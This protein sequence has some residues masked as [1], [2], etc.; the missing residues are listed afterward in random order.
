MLSQ[1]YTAHP[2]LFPLVWDTGDSWGN[3]RYWWYPGNGYVPW[4]T[5]GGT[6]EPTWNNYSDYENAYQQISIQESPLAINLQMYLGRDALTVTTDIEVTGQITT[7]DNKLFLVITTPVTDPDADYVNK[8]VAYSGEFDFNLSQIGETMTHEYSFDLDPGWDLDAIEIIAIVQSWSGT[9]N[10]LQA[11]RSDYN[12]LSPITPSQIDFGQVAIGSSAIEQIT[13]TNYWADEL[14]GMIFPIPNF[15]I[16]DNFTVPAMGSID[17]D[18]TFTPTEEMDY[19]GDIIFTTSHE[20]FPTV[21]VHVTGSGFEDSAVDEHEITQNHLLGNFPN[22]FHTATKISFNV[23]KK[24]PFVTLNIYNLKG[25]KVK[26]FDVIL[27]GVEGKSNSVVWDGTDE[28]GK[29][30]ANGIYYYKLQTGG[31]SQTKK[32]ILMR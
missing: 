3:D 10:I 30:A 31:F 18:L 13:I 25:Q 23:T 15:E 8:V 11:A 32:M 14:T 4:I 21:I 16:V 26:E 27:S 19:E 6:I 1:L 24:S 20:L 7:S 5:F 2:D 12:P 22:P 28:S 9:K 17:V 29:K